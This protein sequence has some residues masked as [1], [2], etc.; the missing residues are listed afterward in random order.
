LPYG[1]VSIESFDE[2][3]RFVEAISIENFGDL[4]K[5]DASGLV[6]V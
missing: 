5:E 2:I 3:F 4:V 1:K 6:D